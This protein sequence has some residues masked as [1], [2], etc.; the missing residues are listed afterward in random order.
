MAYSKDYIERA[1]GYKDE[2]R[3]FAE[4]R[5]AFGIPAATYYDWKE[6]LENGFVFGA[7]AKKERKRKID[8]EQLKQAVREK[9][10]A[11]LHELAQ[12]FGCSVQAVFYMLEKMGITY[13]KNLRI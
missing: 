5:E 3:T 11:Y 9:P 4:L 7:K 8:R 2:G 10:D 6:K 13:K 1:V 12:L